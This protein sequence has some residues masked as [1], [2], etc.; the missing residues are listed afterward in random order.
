MHKN[1]T[2]LLREVQFYRNAFM[3]RAHKQVTF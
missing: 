1:I 2:H 3:R